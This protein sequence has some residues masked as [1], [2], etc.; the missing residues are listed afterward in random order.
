MNRHCTFSPDYLARLIVS[1]A[2]VPTVLV[3]GMLFFPTNCACGADSLHP[4]T[5]LELDGHS[6]RPS[7]AEDDVPTREVIKSGQDGTTVQSPTGPAAPTA[8]GV[9]NTGSP[10]VTL[11]GATIAGDNTVSLSGQTTLPDLPPPQS[12]RLQC[13]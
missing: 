12:D 11:P 1:T 3:A 9:Q 10:S 13:R 6:H 8:D 4:H 2:I 5:I 7:D